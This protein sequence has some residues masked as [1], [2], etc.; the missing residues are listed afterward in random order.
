MANLNTNLYWYN[1]ALGFQGVLSEIKFQH[2]NASFTCFTAQPGSK[3]QDY[4]TNYEKYIVTNKAEIASL[5]GRITKI[6]SEASRHPTVGTRAQRV[7]TTAALLLAYIVLAASLIGIG[8]IAGIECEWDAFSRA[9]KGYSVKQLEK[10]KL[11]LTALGERLKRIEDSIVGLNDL[12]AKA[13][14]VIQTLEQRIALLKQIEP[15]IHAKASTNHM[16][17]FLVDPNSR[18]LHAYESVLLWF[19]QAVL[20]A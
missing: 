2:P 5:N 11:E 15:D 16:W 20:A 8:V 17:Y 7:A 9:S 6:E 1:G 19:K 14:A 10:D 13:P 18:V 12:K 3:V 4:I